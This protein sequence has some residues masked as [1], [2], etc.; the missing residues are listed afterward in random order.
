MSFKLDKA[1]K[2]RFE[3]YEADLRE[4]Q[5]KVEDALATYNDALNALREPVEAA[6]AEYNE[7]VADARG[8]VED[9]ASTASGEIDDKS[10]KWQEGE[11]GQAATEWKDAWE[12]A[13]L[14][15]IAVEFPD[16][17]SI[18]DLNHADTLEQLPV[19]AG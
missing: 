6:L 19:E 16:D 8:F 18:D 12:Q 5:G 13:S 1:D 10:E 2:A 11:R 15:E 17:L 14:D 3:K 4:L 9:I 7:L